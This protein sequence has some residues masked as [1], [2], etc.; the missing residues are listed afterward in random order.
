MI[1]GWITQP[2]LDWYDKNARIL[3]WRETPSPYRVWISEIMLQQTRVEAV[4]PYFEQF[5]AQL[6]DIPALAEVDDDRLMKLW[7]GLGY[8]SRARNLKKAAQVSM[9]RFGG[10]L[11]SSYDDLLKLPGIGPYTAGAI[12]SIAFGIP[13]PAVD[14]NVLRV[15]TRVTADYSNVSESKVKRQMEEHVRDILPDRRAGDM[16][17]ALMELGATVCLPNGVPKCDECPLAELC[18]ANRQGNQMDFPQKRAKKARRMEDKTVLLLYCGGKTAIRKRPETGLL[19]GLFEF[20]NLEGTLLP[21]QVLH[22]VEQWGIEVRSIRPAGN[23]KHI[24]THVEWHMQGYFVEVADQ[25]PLFL[26]AGKEDLDGLYSI[27]SAFQFYNKKRLEET[28]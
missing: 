11:P 16:N 20:P 18:E 12:A 5:V 7:E 23:A 25:S 28:L 8:Y 13:A 14:G 22:Q 24:F 10:R 17:Q 6:P 21:K 27:P 9:E 3:P 2:L 19:A 26:W 15:I 4:K 1:L